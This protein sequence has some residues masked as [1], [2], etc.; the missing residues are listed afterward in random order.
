MHW[1]GRGALL[2]PKFLLKL[3]WDKNERQG[4]KDGEEEEEEQK[5]KEEEEGEEGGGGGGVKRSAVQWWNCRKMISL[6]SASKPF[7]EGLSG[8][9]L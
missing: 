7:M 5:E 4:C 9:R 3:F 1:E 8:L 6:T 2:F